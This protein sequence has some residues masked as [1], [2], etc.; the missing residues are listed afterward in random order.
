MPFI[1][2]LYEL[3]WQTVSV[4]FDHLLDPFLF[5]LFCVLNFFLLPNSYPN[6][7]VMRT[8]YVQLLVFESHWALNLMFVYISFSVLH[9]A[10]PI[11]QLA[12]ISYCS[13]LPFRL[14]LTYVSDLATHNFRFTFQM[15]KSPFLCVTHTWMS[16]RFEFDFFFHGFAF[17]FASYWLYCLLTIFPD[18]LALIIYSK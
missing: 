5:I 18:Y 16:F 2:S 15:G 9:F 10:L 3:S 11:G 14:L 13:W 17:S 4:L 12:K 8:L 6:V 1:H 7:I